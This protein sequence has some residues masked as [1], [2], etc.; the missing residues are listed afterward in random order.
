MTR[1]APVRLTPRPPTLVVKRKIKMELSYKK[2]ER[3][4]RNENCFVKSVN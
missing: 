1:L 2:T 3:F 4:L